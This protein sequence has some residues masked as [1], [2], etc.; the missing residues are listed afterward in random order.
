MKRAWRIVW[1]KY[2]LTAGV[3]AVWLVFLD[4]NS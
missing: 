2:V 4:S 3:F 1:N